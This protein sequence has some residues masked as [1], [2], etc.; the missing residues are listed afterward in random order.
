MKRFS[1]LSRQLI[2]AALGLTFTCSLMAADS[3]GDGVDDSLD[4]AIY[5]ANSSQLD[6]NGDGFGNVADPDFNNDHFTN[7]VDLAYF[8]S[9][10]YT[11]NLNPDADLDG[12][13]FVGNSDLSILNSLF[14][15]PPGPSGIAENINPGGSL[16]TGGVSAGS[17]SLVPA[18]QNVA[19]GDPVDFQLIIDFTGDATLGGAIDIVFDPSVISFLSFDFE[20]G[21]ASSPYSRLP[22]LGVGELT[23]LAF[24]SMA[25]LDSALIGTLTFDSIGNGI[26]SL[27]MTESFVGGG[28]Y[29]FDSFAQE[30]VFNSAEVTVVP[31]PAAVW[32]FGSGLLGLIGVS[33]RKKTA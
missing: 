5:V 13:G 31:V 16:P 2:F 11:T 9:V 24:G 4:N 19:H 32:L 27:S 18:S 6:T 22:D 3:D 23:G 33:T 25:G 17:V 1:S 30:P 14:F 10:L 26:S 15:Q 8:R 21:F 7:F 12:D 28:F 20:P 29:S